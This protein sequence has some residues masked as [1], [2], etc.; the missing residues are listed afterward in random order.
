MCNGL[1]TNRIKTISSQGAKYSR[2]AGYAQGSTTIPY[3]EYTQ[4]SGNSIH[5]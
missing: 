4:V 1:K 3:Q 5:P 2:E